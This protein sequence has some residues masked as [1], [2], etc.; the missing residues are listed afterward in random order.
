MLL[1]EEQALVK[2]VLVE[3]LAYDLVVSRNEDLHQQQVPVQK[4]VLLVL[5]RGE[6]RFRPYHIEAIVPEPHAAG[7]ARAPDTLAVSLEQGF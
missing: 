3:L 4:I 7:A 1:V 2:N 5:C 6:V